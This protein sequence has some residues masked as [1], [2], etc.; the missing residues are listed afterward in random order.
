M[1]PL[2]GGLNGFQF[3]GHVVAG[4]TGAHGLYFAQNANSARESHEADFVGGTAKPDE[5]F[6]GGAAGVVSVRFHH[7]ARFVEEQDDVETSHGL[8]GVS[9]ERPLEK[10]QEEEKIGENR[11]HV[12]SLRIIVIIKPSETR[13]KGRESISL[14]P[15]LSGAQEGKNCHSHPTIPPKQGLCQAII[16][17]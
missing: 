5:K 12:G 7:A 10:K 11:F 2:A 14:F 9:L 17:R 16:P 6:G 8:G 3:R 4:G 1:G 13:R 15:R